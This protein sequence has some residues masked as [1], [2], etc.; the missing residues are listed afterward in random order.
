VKHETKIM[1]PLR[2]R[3][4]RYTVN[5][6]RTGDVTLRTPSGR[7]TAWHGHTDNPAAA[8]AEWLETFPGAGLVDRR[9][10]PASAR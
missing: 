6:S 8:A 4:D 9:E 10:M 3:W 1:K 2:K 5:I 7:T